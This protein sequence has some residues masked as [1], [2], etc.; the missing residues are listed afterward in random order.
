M[1]LYLDAPGS[2]LDAGEDGH[3]NMKW[4]GAIIVIIGCGAIGY[5][6]AWEHLRLERMLRDMIQI[7]EYMQRDLQYRLLPLP[8]L[9]R[10]GVDLGKGT[11]HRIFIAIADEMDNQISPD[12]EHCVRAALSRYRQIPE[13]IRTVFLDL[14]KGFGRFG[15]EGQ[16]QALMGVRGTCEEKL[17]QLLK[18]KDSRQRSYQTLGLCA[19]A[20]MVILFI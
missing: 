17:A 6:M 1:S 12:A 3:M 10:Q 19:G 7:V 9:C 11:V 5:H 18:N 8:L 2:I 20:A 15:L 4:I 13:D 16:L 14:G